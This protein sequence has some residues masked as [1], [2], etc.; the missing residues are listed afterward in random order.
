MKYCFVFVTVIYKKQI[1][2]W[3]EGCRAVFPKKGDLGLAKNVTLI[4]IAA[5]VF[6]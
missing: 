5:K 6:S 3:A 1:Q 4:S 2:R